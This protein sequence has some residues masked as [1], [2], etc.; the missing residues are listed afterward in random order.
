MVATSMHYII[1][2]L[3]AWFFGYKGNKK[4][5]HGLWAAAFDLDGIIFL[6]SMIL[7]RFFGFASLSTANSPLLT[8][9][10]AH[11]G[12]SHSFLLIAI[13]LGI[14]FLFRAKLK[15]IAM[16]AVMLTSHLL[17]DFLTAW[18][19]FPFLPFS[20]TSTYLA[21]VE[22]F[23]PMLTFFTMIIFAFFIC[24]SLANKRKKL[25]L[26]FAYVFV[27]I[28]GFFSSILMGEFNIQ[29][30]ILSQVIF[31]FIVILGYRAKNMNR[32]YDRFGKKAINFTLYVTM[33][34]LG[35]LLISKIGYGI[36]L[37][38]SITNIEPLEEFAFNYNA[39]TFEIDQGDTYKIGI[40]S[41]KGI[42]Q[43]KIIPKVN[44]YVGLDKET[45]N[46]YFKAYEKA[47]YINWFNHPVFSFSQDGDVYANIRYAKS[48]LDTEHLPGPRNGMNVKLENGML[49]RYGKWFD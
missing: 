27:L 41:L 44:D 21:L 39:H 45:V 5:W 28:F 24:M 4:Y 15:L 9:L 32:K 6:G 2:I 40:I 14:M 22:V 46:E 11:R 7:S 30:I 17:L 47:L 25:P 49:T 38:T 26:I 3:I 13:V 43:E 34:Y 37:N 18:K 10:F 29:T 12:F 33:A 42:E 1:G 31:W 20:Y 19:M 35:L 16:I 8:A 36:A 23:D 48:Y